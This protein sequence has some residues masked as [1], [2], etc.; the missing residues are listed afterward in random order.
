MVRKNIFWNQ[1][2][3]FFGEIIFGL[4]PT[5]L[6]LFFSDVPG[7]VLDLK[8]VVTNRKM[9]LL[10]WSDPEDDGGSDIIGFIVERKDAK[11]HTWRLAIDTERS[12][13]D[14]TGLVEGQEYK[15]RV[16]AK[17]KFGTGPAVEIGPILA[18]DPLGKIIYDLFMFFFFLPVRII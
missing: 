14:I 16:S 15:F 13:C 17:N 18:V 9:C 1:L 5:C 6:I 4:Y 11:M 10:N 8:P 2:S 3:I 7:P 12:K